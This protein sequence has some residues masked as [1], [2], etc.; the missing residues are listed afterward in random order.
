MTKQWTNVSQL[1]FNSD[2]YSVGHPALSADGKTLYFASDMPGGIGETDIYAT[3]LI[4]E[5][6][7]KKSWSKPENLGDKI[8][9]QGGEMF[10][11]LDNAGNLW[12][13]SNGQPGIGGL[14]VFLAAKDKDGFK[15]PVNPGYPVNTRFDDFGFITQNEGMDAYLSSDR[16][17]AVRDDDIFIIKRTSKSNE[18]PGEADTIKVAPV[19][20]SHEV[21]IEGKVFSAE[22][23]KPIPNAI[24]Y[25]INKADSSKRE[26]ISDGTG[27]FSFELQPEADYIVE[28]SVTKS[29]NKCSSVLQKFQHAE[30]KGIH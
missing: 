6:G 24:A 1:P 27:A 4:N 11:F 19:K 25:L 7:D 8:N 2:Q 18:S 30:L 21:V 12:Y 28:V 17:K 20:K 15:S 29:G 9:T 3:H 13:A 26:V 22:D 14:D 10:P 5:P 23:F 16:Y